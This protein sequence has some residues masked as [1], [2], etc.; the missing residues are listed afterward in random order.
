L[1]SGPKA[2]PQHV[3]S[4]R[5]SDHRALAFEGGAGGGRSGRRDRQ[6]PRDPSGA[7]MIR[8]RIRKGFSIAI[9][10][11]SEY[12]APVPKAVFDHHKPR[13]HASD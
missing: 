12:D 10:I 2:S 7:A 11:A 1:L 6:R 13:H 8:Q 9:T 4:A 3:T 5:A